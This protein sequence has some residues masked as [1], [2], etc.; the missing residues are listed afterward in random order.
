VA[1]VL[2]D[3]DGTLLQGASSERL[4]FLHLL[5]HGHLGRRQL[6]A[7]LTFCLRWWPVY[8][9][10]VFKKNKAYLAGLT[11][12]GIDSIAQSFVQ[13]HLSRHMRPS[14]MR[15]LETHRQAGDT[16][17]LLTGAP[18]F[19]ARPLAARVGAQAYSA[20]ECAVENGVFATRPPRIHPFGRDKLPQAQ[21][22]CQQIGCPLGT[23]MAYADSFY[24]VPLLRSVNRAVAVHPDRRLRKVALR[25]GWEIVDG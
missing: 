9:R 7:A 19:I 25:E 3:L 22:L 5:A 1:C 2:L 15:R 17:A 23:C 12:S 20:T 11:V 10:H 18:G 16:L 14:L 24:D 4:F 8:G 21:R 13:Q 6:S